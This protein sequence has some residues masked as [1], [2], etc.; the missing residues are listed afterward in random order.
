[1]DFNT[2]YAAQMMKRIVAFQIKITSIQGKWKLNQNQSDVRRERVA[3]KLNT[4]TSEGDL[5][6]AK[7][8]DEDMAG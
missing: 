7:L 8:M 2:D 5:Q 3:A 1:M 4:S 6:V